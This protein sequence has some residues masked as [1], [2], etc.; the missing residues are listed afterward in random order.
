MGNLNEIVSINPSN[1]E[2]IWRGKVTAQEELNAIVQKAKLAQKEWSALSLKE[3][4]NIL[5]KFGEY[6]D[7][8]VDEA[9]KIISEENG[10]PYWE[11]KTEVKSL[12]NKIQVV[13]DA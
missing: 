3:R 11:A 9:A 10:K 13:F 6:V 12:T 1:N 8:H 5:R 7:A 2:V 4:E